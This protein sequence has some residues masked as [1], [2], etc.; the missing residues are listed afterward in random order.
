MTT[1]L[2]RI[3]TFEDGWQ[4]CHSWQFEADDDADAK[5]KAMEQV[6]NFGTISTVSVTQ[7]VEPDTT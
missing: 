5:R 1:Y 4:G 6:S 2:L 3:N 7:V